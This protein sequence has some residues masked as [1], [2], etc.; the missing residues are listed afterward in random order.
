MVSI[1]IHHAGN[2][3]FDSLMGRYIYIFILSS[4]ANL[5]GNLNWKTSFTSGTKMSLHYWNL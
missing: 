4:L 5:A 3:V 1:P 2:W